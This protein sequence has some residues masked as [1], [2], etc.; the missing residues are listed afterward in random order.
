VLAKVVQAFGSIGEQLTVL[1]SGEAVRSAWLQTV[2][3]FASREGQPNKYASVATFKHPTSSATAE[4]W[5][6]A[7]RGDVVGNAPKLA[8]LG[9]G[10]VS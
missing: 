6:A 1:P 3:D 2:N 5:L 4:E 10:P 7:K 9:G 8:D